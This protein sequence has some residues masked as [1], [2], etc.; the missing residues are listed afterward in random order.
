MTDKSIVLH[1][2]AHKTATT[3][4]QSWCR[5]HL[6][7][8]RR[9]GLVFIDHTDKEYSTYRIIRGTCQAARGERALENSAAKFEMLRRSLRRQLDQPTVKSILIPW[10]IFLGE[11]YYH[12]IAGFYPKSPKSIDA[13]SQLFDG[14]SVKVIYTIRDQGS[15]V[16]SWYQQLQKLGRRLA[17]EPYLDWAVTTDLSWRPIIA[18]LVAAFG[19]AQVKVLD[20]TSPDSANP[21]ILARILHAY[22]IPTHSLLDLE[23]TFKNKAWPKQAMDIAAFAMPKLD[24]RT[25]AELRLLLDRGFAE[26]PAAPFSILDEFTRADFSSRYQ[27][28]LAHFKTLPHAS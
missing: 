5:T 26:H 21:D 18:N 13:C 9:H 15:F 14:F 8:L 16:N 1:L 25:A 11:P 20:Y 2:G 28:D 27:E 23:H 4:A 17:P 10:E 19:V 6:T 24:A 22:G 12:G 3:S 7:E